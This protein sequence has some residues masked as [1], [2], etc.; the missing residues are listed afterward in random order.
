MW[1]DPETSLLTYPVWGGGTLEF[2][3][4]RSGGGMSVGTSPL[5]ARLN[6]PPEAGGTDTPTG[7]FVVSGKLSITKVKAQ[8]D[9]EKFKSGEVFIPAWLR[10]DMFEYHYKL[11]KNSEPKTSFVSN[12]LLQEQ[13][14]STLRAERDDARA[15]RDNLRARLKEVLPWVGFTPFSATQIYELSLI[16]DLAKD[17]LV[18]ITEDVNR[19]ENRNLKL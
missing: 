13:Y 15:Q 17:S 3:M 16:K 11:L 12:G 1:K 2:G 19:R 14:D 9:D 10:A 6:I 8:F 18:E 7:W 4:A 5:M